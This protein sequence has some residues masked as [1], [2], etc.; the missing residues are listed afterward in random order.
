MTRRSP[1]E[2]ALGGTLLL[3]AALAAAG[4]GERGVGHRDIP[5]TELIVVSRG[6]RPLLL[7][8]VWYLSAPRKSR[9]VDADHVALDEVRGRPLARTLIADV[10]RA[11]PALAGV[12]RLATV[13]GI[14]R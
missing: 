7:G 8:P 11:K 4:S 2:W 10:A 5:E 13:V 12:T 1:G 6:P 14:T 9:E 3:Q